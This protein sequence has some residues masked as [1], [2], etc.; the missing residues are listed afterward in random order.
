MKKREPIYE[1]IDGRQFPTQEDADRHEALATAEHDFLE[2]RQRLGVLLAKSQKTADGKPF[3][4]DVY[5]DYFYV[6]PGWQGM[7]HLHTVSFGHERFD[8]DA[9]DRFQLIVREG[10]KERR[11][12]IADL[13]AS[14]DEAERA[15]L[16]AQE[17][18]L[19]ERTEE[20]AQMRE[21]LCGGATS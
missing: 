14:K 17:A 21:R 10:E 9:Q 8:F 5:D 19:A 4:F 2:A 13:Y 18:W 15:L 6:S 11:Y 1:C 16:T 7:P 3:E 12:A 20:V